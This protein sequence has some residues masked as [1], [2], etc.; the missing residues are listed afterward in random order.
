MKLPAE[1]MMIIENGIDFK[2]F[3]AVSCE[4][5]AMRGKLGYGKDDFVILNPASVYGAKNQMHLISGFARAY[6]KNSSLRLL[7]A[8]KIIEQPYFDRCVELIKEYG[9]ENAVS[10][11]N[12]FD[13]MADIYNACDA[14]AL[15]SFWE[16]CSLAA[17]EAIHF[18][19]PL[20]ASNTGDIERQTN[21]KN[22]VIFDLPFKYFTDFTGENFCDIVFN[23]SEELTNSIADGIIKLANRDYAV[24]EDNLS[25]TED[26]DKVFSR[27]LAML[28]YQK[29]G[30]AVP[31]VRH[32][33]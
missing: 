29:G 32:N 11:G 23:L 13:N 19:K 26:T 1:K 8:G 22:C 24:S 12:Y 33:I 30:L 16:G 6:A 27:Y 4:R 10:I 17:A 18:K 21:R 28:N 3:K 15:P 25:A 7:I 5:D 2:R 31:A 20:L 9:I 14:V